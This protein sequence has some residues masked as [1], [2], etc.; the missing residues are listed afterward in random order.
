LHKQL[1]TPPSCCKSNSNLK[2]KRRSTMY[3]EDDSKYDFLPFLDRNLGRVFVPGEKHNTKLFVRDFRTSEFGSRLVSEDLD[4]GE[5]LDA[6]LEAAQTQFGSE[7]IN[8]QQFVSVAKSLWML[9]ELKPKPAPVAQAPAQKPLSTSQLAWQEFRNFTESHSV[10]E[11]KARARTDAAYGKFLHTNLQREMNDSPVADGV[12]AVGTEAIR[13]DKTIRINE[14][15]R[16]FAISYRTM[17]SAEVRKNSN[18]LTNPN[19]TEWNRK[20]DLA[21]AA[22]LL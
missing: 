2:E 10:A 1:A 8:M 5:N 17:S 22:G 6:I 12:V 18:Q 21:I 7:E 9:G 16:A 15:L 20:V 3:N 14:D 4:T 13:Q 11:C 19:A